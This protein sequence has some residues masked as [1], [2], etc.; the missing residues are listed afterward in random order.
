M[1][2]PQT[3]KFQSKPKSKTPAERSEEFDS[4]QARLKAEAAERRAAA[5]AKASGDAKA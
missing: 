4:V 3:G 2:A 5:A 1:A